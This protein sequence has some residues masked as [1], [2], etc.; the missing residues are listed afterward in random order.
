MAAHQAA[1]LIFS[2]RP[3]PLHLKPKTQR[4]VPTTPARF[5][6]VP[7]KKPPKY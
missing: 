7:D 6:S 2:G 4:G 3:R 5:C 1:S